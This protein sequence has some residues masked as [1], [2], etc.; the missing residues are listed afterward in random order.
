MV[1]CYGS[2]NWLSIPKQ[3]DNDDDADDASTVLFYVSGKIL[4]A[5]QILT[6]LIYTGTLWGRDFYYFHFINEE[7]ELCRGYTIYLALKLI[8]SATRT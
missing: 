3:N 6:D 2:P 8:G 4:G 7:V 1:F 5:M